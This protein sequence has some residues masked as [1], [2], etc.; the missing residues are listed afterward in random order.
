MNSC[1]IE[2]TK[3]HVLIWNTHKPIV[4]IFRL[5][6]AGDK[7]QRYVIQHR[8]EQFSLMTNHTEVLHILDT[9]H[10]DSLRNGKLLP[11]INEYETALYVIGS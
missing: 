6:I 10:N 2:I 9:H 8:F 11:I 3:M 5:R 4:Q 7:Q 1:Q